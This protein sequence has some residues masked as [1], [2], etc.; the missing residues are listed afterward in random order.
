MDEIKIEGIKGFGHHGLFPEEKR[1][2]Q[3]FFVDLILQRDLRQAGASD[4]I[5]LTIDYGA[6]AIRVKEIIETGSFNLI[7]RLATVIAESLKAEFDLDAVTV[8]VH[9]PD[10]PVD[11]E[12][13]DI[14]VTIR[15]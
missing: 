11:L 3:E 4:D 12:F 6:V 8:T 2:G 10:A 7:E 5:A 9:K 14:S 1:D 15:R 13:K